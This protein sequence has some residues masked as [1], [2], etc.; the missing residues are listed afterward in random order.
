VSVSTSAARYQDISINPEKLAGQC[1]KLKCCMNYEVDAY[2]EAQRKLPSREIML[3]T[4]DSKYYHFKTDVFSGMMTYSTDKHNAIN[5]IT[6]SKERVFEVIAMNKEGKKPN[7]LSFS[8]EQ[9]EKEPT[10]VDELLD[11]SIT[12]F[13]KDK[14]QSGKNKRKRTRTKRQNNQNN[15]QENKHKTPQGNKNSQ[16]KKLMRKDKNDKK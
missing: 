8:A 16:E 9:T 13:D 10:F 12:R 1:S 4:R 7:K 5:L 11:Q 3:E 2:V 14:N 6:V 15:Q